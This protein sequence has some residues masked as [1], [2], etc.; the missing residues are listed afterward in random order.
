[1]KKITAS[2]IACLL[3]IASSISQIN[4]NVTD[5]RSRQNNVNSNTT[6]TRNRLSATRGEKNAAL[7]E[8]E[9]LDFELDIVSEEID[10]ITGEL[11]KTTLLLQQTEL[12][13]IKAEN[14]RSLQYEALKSRV[15]YM[16]ENGV[17]G[18]VQILF[19][20]ASISDFLNRIDYINQ[21]ISYDNNLLGKLQ[22]TENLI[23]T[24]KTC[25]V[26]LIN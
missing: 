9:D 10:F 20:A 21:I 22:T 24:V 15:R 25:R 18:Y 3:V 17:T 5:L 26:I 14:N 4:A 8:I 12:D 7:A 19:K 13:L 11:D 16:Y 23:C 6:D 1:L 2:I